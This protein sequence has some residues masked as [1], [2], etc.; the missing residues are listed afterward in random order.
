LF[1]F[2]KIN[3]FTTGIESDQQFNIL[4]TENDQE[5]FDFFTK[6]EILE[7]RRFIKSYEEEFKDKI[8]DKY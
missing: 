4:S 8:E 7:A 5:E 1:P 3:L 2:L 6:L